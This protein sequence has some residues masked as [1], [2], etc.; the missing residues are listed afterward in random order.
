[1]A[2]SLIAGGKILWFGNGGSAADA[3]HLAAELVGRFR[4]DRRALPSLALTTDTSVLTALGN[5]YGYDSIFS[6][7]IEALCHPGDV[8]VGIT[9]SGKSANVLRGLT[10]ARHVGAV[11]IAFTGRSGLAIEGA[12]DWTIP[13]PV[14]E[15]SHVQ[16]AHIVVGQLL[17]QLVE[18]RLGYHA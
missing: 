1:M 5:D 10:Q 11:T 13:V 14:N 12:S 16:E 17:C 9:T 4:S 7:Q 6:R 15:T 3:Q 2:D 18:E 8:A